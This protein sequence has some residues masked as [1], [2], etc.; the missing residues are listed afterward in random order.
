MRIVVKN[1]PE[2]TKEKELEDY[3]GK[4]GTV[5]DVYLLKN[6]KGAFRR[7]CFIGFKTEDEAADSQKYYNQTYFKNHKITVELAQEDNHRAEEKNETQLRKALYSKTVVIRNL[8]DEVSKEEIQEALEKI[9]KVVEIRLEGRDSNVAAIVKFKE[10][11][12]AEKALRAVKLIA[13][14]RVRVGNY[15]ENIA[16]S[17]REHYN[18]LFF[19]FD[20]IVNRI[21]EMEKIEKVHLVNLDDKE[22]GT[23]ISLLES[24][25]VNETKKFL[26]HNNIFIDKIGQMKSRNVLILR[27]SDLHSVLDLIAGDFKVS[28]APSRC[29]ALLDFKDTA[30]AEKCYK[31]MNM[32][33]H[34]NQV[35]YCE[36][37]PICTK[38]DEHSIE[39]EKPAVCKDTTKIIVKNIPFQATKEELKRLFSSFTH[40]VDVRLPKKPDGKH[41]GFGFIVLDSMESADK[42]IEYFG[43]S[44]HLYGRRLVLEKAKA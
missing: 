37:A 34:K 16:D 15:R 25:L 22:L 19:N 33:R 24:N 38:P 13:G 11:E 27:N 5:T 18:S 29:L 30:M 4:K 42:A 10:G 26:A 9:G 7:I 12:C 32:K 44:T 21:C 14:R 28:I 6:A 40:V 8:G 31:E 3:F 39:E 1:L 17:V 41:R 36:Y 2:S 35:I 43:S 20:T 23:R